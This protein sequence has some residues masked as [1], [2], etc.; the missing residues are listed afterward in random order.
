MTNKF[1][2]YVFLKWQ[3]N[4]SEKINNAYSCC[5][6]SLY[7]SSIL[8]F[9]FN[10]GGKQ[11][12]LLL[13]IFLPKQSK[14]ES[15]SLTWYKSRGNKEMQQ[16]CKFLFYFNIIS[17]SFLLVILIT[18]DFNVVF[19]TTNYNPEGISY[20]KCRSRVPQLKSLM[21]HDNHYYLTAS[22]IEK[23]LIFISDVSLNSY[24]KQYIGM[25]TQQVFMD[26]IFNDA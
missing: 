6:Y 17:M 21:L 13:E 11:K 15:I 26:T 2:Q 7:S 10:V 12:R 8:F 18:D 3:E 25:F 16:L 1:L 24:F 14:L 22:P 4:N 5:F 20:F 23:A 9:S 19:L